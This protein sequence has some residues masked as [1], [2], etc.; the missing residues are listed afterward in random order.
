MNPDDAL[1]G[2]APRRPPSAAAR[3]VGL[4]RTTASVEAIA[5]LAALYDEGVGACLLRRR[6]DPIVER[7]VDSALLPRDAERR[8]V[9]AADAP[10]LG[11]LLAPGEGAEGPGAWLDDVR[12]LVEIFAA[13]TGAPAV[14]V[15][16]RSGGEPMCPRFHVDRVAVRLV[17]AYAGP[18]TEWLDGGDVDRSRLG[19]AAGGLPDEAS[20]LLRE[21]AKVWRAAPFDLVLL[22]GEA[23]PGNEG[24]GAVHRSP[25]FWGRRVVLTLDALD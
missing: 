24:H 14:G 16:V 1:P 8:L 12:E 4:A 6:A 20:G 2:L 11:D 15:R 19:H 18:G 10:A 22:K 17:C 25:P 9:V 7:F 21:G 13:L 3:L 5:D 23:W